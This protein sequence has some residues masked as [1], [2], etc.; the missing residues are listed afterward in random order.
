MYFGSKEE[1]FLMLLREQLESWY[2]EV[3]KKLAARKSR[4]S[5]TQLARMLA[6]TLGG[7][8]ELTRLLGL[9]PGVLEGNMEIVEAYRFHLWHKERMEE[10]GR[11][12]ERRARGLEKGQ[13]LRLLHLLQVWAGALDHLSNPRGG[14]AVNLLD[15]DFED[16]KVDMVEELKVFVTRFL[17][18]SD[19]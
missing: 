9:S 8:L 11:E 19:S 1:L 12:L 17:S 2:S 14:L 15:P 4:C 3:E 7:R 5:N 10:V 16:L 18:G 6:G 13:G